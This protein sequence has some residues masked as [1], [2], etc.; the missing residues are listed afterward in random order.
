[1]RCGLLEGDVVGSAS[2]TK[3]I[4]MYVSLEEVRVVA[5]SRST[6]T[7]E[8]E[9]SPLG[10]ADGGSVLRLP[11]LVKGRR[12]DLLLSPSL[13]RLEVFSNSRDR[14]LLKIARFKLAKRTSA[15]NS[16][17]RSICTRLGAERFLPPSRITGKRNVRSIRMGYHKQSTFLLKDAG[18]VP[19]A[20][21]PSLDLP[22]TS[23]PARSRVGWWM[24]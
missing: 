24:S 3:L 2:M 6:T 11:P 23:A 4:M 19:F 8:S 10:H 15:T 5:F 7:I 17:G 16:L 20:S 12:C 1:M 21:V 13:S 22:E 18:V 9:G 14:V